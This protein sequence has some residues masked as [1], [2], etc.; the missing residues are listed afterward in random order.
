MA[1]LFYQYEIIQLAEVEYT[2]LKWFDTELNNK[3]LS[4]YKPTEELTQEDLLILN[5][6]IESGMKLENKVEIQKDFI[7]IQLN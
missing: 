5:E 7:D 1:R 4:I 2:S 3:T 6:F